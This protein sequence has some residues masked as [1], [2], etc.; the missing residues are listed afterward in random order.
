M[1][2][3]SVALAALVAVAVAGG[4]L[5]WFLVGEPQAR[6]RAAAETVEAFLSSWE[7]GDWSAL[8]ARVAAAEREQ[9]VAAHRRA[10]AAVEL[11]NFE[12]VPLRVHVDGEH[13]EAAYRAAVDVAGVGRHR[14]EGSFDLT[15]DGSAWV[16][17]WV[18]QVVHPRM[19]AGGSFAQSRTWPERAAILDRDGV[20][21]AGSDETVAVGVE[22][23][24]I[25]DAQQVVDA[26]VAN[27]GA[28]RER[29]ETLLARE[30]LVEDW[31]YPVV[32]LPRVLFEAADPRLRPVP[33]IVF[34][35]GSGGRAGVGGGSAG[36][37][38]GRTGDATADEAERLGA[39]YREGD[40]VGS[41]GVEAALEGRLAGT[42]ELLLAVVDEHGAVVEVLLKL[43][44]TTPE[45]V[46]LALDRRVQAAADGVL[47]GDGPPAALVAVDV[48]TGEVLAVANR[49]VTGY[50]R[51]FEGRYPPGSTFKVVTAAA[52]LASGLGPG[53]VLDCPETAQVGGRAFR[54]A[55]ALALGEITLAEAFAQSCNTAFVGRAPGLGDA[56]ASAAGTFGFDGRTWLPVPSFSGS[57]P[58]PSDATELAAAAIGQGRVEASPLHMATVAAAAAR[59][60]WLPPVLVLGGGGD[61]P[62]RPLPGAAGL[63]DMLLRAVAEGT[64]QAAAL[65]GEPVGGKT[66]SAEFGAA[67]PPE[68]HAWF[69]GFRGDLAFAVLVEGGG[70]GGEVAAPLARAFLETLD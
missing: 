22:P 43:E 3:V 37:L 8:A 2:K 52:L 25:T 59:G 33:G 35:P 50:N 46:R 48:P 17:G 16:V 4:A 40:V 44:A 65:P 68:T 20:T 14:Y 51:A 38:V 58:D 66:G 10:F 42:P 6:Q 36:Q 15:W 57:F 34:R 27:A 53:A 18:P 13:A 31:F 24:R 64:G 54:N 21:L 29:V 49:P 19:V 45:E 30:D 67:S 1:R 32:E 12:I 23:R 47:A 61:E 56:L 70:A 11:T 28:S 7:S 60:A 5:W 9:A 41:Y 63:R 69:I 62:P 39:H 26:L 55:G